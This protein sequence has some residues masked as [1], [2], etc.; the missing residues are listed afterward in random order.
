MELAVG[1]DLEKRGYES[2]GEGGWQ[3]EKSTCKYFIKSTAHVPDARALPT[4][5]HVRLVVGTT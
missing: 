4:T 2:W 5:P 3:P 1:G